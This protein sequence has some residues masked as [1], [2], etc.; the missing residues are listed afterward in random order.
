MTKTTNKVVKKEAKVVLEKAPTVAVKE[1]VLTNEKKDP[2]VKTWHISL[3]DKPSKEAKELLNNNNIHCFNDK[4]NNNGVDTWIY[5]VRCSNLIGGKEITE[6]KLTKWLN[7]LLTGKQPVNKNK[8]PLMMTSPSYD[9][10][11]K[12]RQEEKAKKSAEKKS[13]RTSAK[14][15]TTTS[16]NNVATT[17]VVETEYKDITMTLEKYQEYK[18]IGFKMILVDVTENNEVLV[19]IPQ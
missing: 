12:Q 17:K 8:E 14:S 15:E 11:V 3:T 5:M 13:T 6:E 1:I 2:T 10:I 4:K 9:A 19:R 18:K 7:I 16:E